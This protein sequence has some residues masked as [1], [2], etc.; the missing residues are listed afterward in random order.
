MCEITECISCMT[1]FMAFKVYCMFQ[2]YQWV[3]Q[4]RCNSS[5]SAMELSLSCTN[6]AICT[7][8]MYRCGL[9]TVSFTHTLQGY[10]AGTEI[11]MH[12][13][14]IMGM[15]V[16]QITSLMM[17]CSIVSSGVDQRKLQ[18]SVLLA[19]MKHCWFIMK[20]VLLHNIGG[21][22]MGNI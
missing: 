19:F 16:S 12:Y 13:S 18:S 17:I 21:N 22:F 15:V 14:D 20:K 4:E 5:V 3:V 11:I 6:P 9:V 7:L 10:C 2:E 8:V 1:V